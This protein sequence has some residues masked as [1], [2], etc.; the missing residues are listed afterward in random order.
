[1]PV[2]YDEKSTTLLHIDTLDNQDLNSDE[3]ELRMGM[4]WQYPRTKL[5]T[6]LVDAHVHVCKHAVP[7][8]LKLKKAHFDSICEA[9]ILWLCKA[10]T[11]RTRRQKYNSVLNPITNTPTNSLALQQATSY[12]PSSHKSKAASS[13]GSLVSSPS[14]NKEE[15]DAEPL[16]LLYLELNRAA[17]KD[18]PPPAHDTA[19]VDMKSNVSPD[20]L[21]G[22]RSTIKRSVVGHHC[23]FGKNMKLV[24]CKLME[25]C[26]V[27]DGVKPDGCILGKNTHVG[28]HAELVRC[29][30]Q[31]G[32]EV[33]PGG[34]YKHEF[35]W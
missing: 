6:R 30:T 18:L 9:L 24:G 2:S 34:V 15:G 31:A 19:L 28:L 17:L 4:L 5:T 26:V 3:L 21:V 16:S 12:H 32:C 11:Q 29:I 33:E 25:Y 35:F 23:V 10:Q 8:A 1:M 20:S 14:M 13:V 7:D 27:E 22:E